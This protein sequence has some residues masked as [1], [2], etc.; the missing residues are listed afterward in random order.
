MTGCTRTV[1]VFTGADT[2]GCNLI[3]DV[4]PTPRTENPLT[5]KANRKQQDQEEPEKGHPTYC[6]H[7]KLVSTTLM[8]IVK[9]MATINARTSTG[10]N[11]CPQTL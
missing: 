2:L 8:Q 9:A 3:T 4:N 10:I 11:E 7:F 6:L 5:V 1:A